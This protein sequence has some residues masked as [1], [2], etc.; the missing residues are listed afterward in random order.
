M[1]IDWRRVFVVTISIFAITS[2][3]TA[4]PVYDGIPRKPQGLD[5][6]FFEMAGHVAGFAGCFFDDNGDLNVLLTDL[7]READ[8]R[9]LVQSFAESRPQR[10]NQPWE[11]AAQIV[12][13]PAEFD[14][15]ELQRVRWLI[16]REVGGFDGVHMFDIDETRNRVI[17]EVESDAVRDAVLAA[18]KNMAVPS[19][20][21][22]INV[23]PPARYASTLQDNVL[24]PAGGVSIEFDGK[25]CTLGVNVW[26][27]RTPYVPTGTDGFFTASHCSRDQGNM[28]GGWKAADGTA[29]TQGG[30][31][32]GTEAYDPP[33]FSYAT[34]PVNCPYTQT[35]LT[36]RYSDVTF[37]KYNT[38]GTAAHGYVEQTLSP[39]IGLGQAG[40]LQITSPAFTITSTACCPLAG[41]MIDKIGRATGWTEGW[42]RKK[43]GG[44]TCADYKPYNTSTYILCSY[45][46]EA[47]AAAG[48]SGAPVVQ[49]LGNYNVAFTGIVWGEQSGGLWFSDI[50]QIAKDMGPATNYLRY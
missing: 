11:R 17:V 29:Y 5:G 40:S 12:V 26:Y 14:F 15:I 9:L 46:A 2:R 20:A 7:S 31:A 36:C 6:T 47:Y 13:K 37:V 27:T 38:A 8:A 23:R 21:I 41:Y 1:H 42:V 39:G 32:I 33:L 35:G 10:W 48:D 24:Q 50:S 28:T 4:Q 34:D 3:L 18:I 25:Q 19:N 49:M 44:S 45:Y 30:V 43:S 16:Q 22:E